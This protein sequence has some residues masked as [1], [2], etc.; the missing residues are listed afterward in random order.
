MT[1]E[2]KKAQDI[3]NETNFIFGQKGSFEDAFPMIED[4]RIE[5]IRKKGVSIH[6][7]S[8]TYVYTKRNPPGEYI[9]CD[10]PY[11]YNGG[12]AIG[13]IIREMVRERKSEGEIPYTMCR[14][15][16]GSPKGK[17]KYGNCYRNYKG[18]INILYKD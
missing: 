18:K 14:G 8:Q 3:F 5:V 10:D 13:N 2:R 16:I 1:I 4:I 6:D 7:E 9:N 11:C 12:L 15:Y 17:R